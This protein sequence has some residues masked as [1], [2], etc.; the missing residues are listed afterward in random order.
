MTLWGH[1]RRWWQG[2]GQP[3][4]RGQTSSSWQR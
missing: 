2:L 3:A 1:L 4:R